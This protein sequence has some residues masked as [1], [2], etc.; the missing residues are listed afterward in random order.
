MDGPR[1]T[2]ELSR[3]AAAVLQER[4]IE[5]ARL[6]AE[7][8]LASVLGLK[9]LDLY[10]QFDR[11]VA[12]PELER[13]RTVIRRRLR[14][15]PV[16]YI[17][18]EAAFRNLVLHVDR[19]VLI[20]RPETEILVGE[21]LKW[22][23][24]H[25]PETALDIG[26]G[27]GAIALS[28][29]RESGLARIVATDASEDALAMAR[30]NAVRLGLADRIEF[31]PG[32]T[33]AAVAPESRFDI[34]ASNPPYVAE[35]DRDTLEPEVREYEPAMALFAGP[36]GLA[37]V[38]AIVSGAADRLTAGGLLALEVGQG[39]AS[40][41]ARRIADTGRFD[42]ARIVDDLAGCARVVLAESQ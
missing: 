3:Q 23:T 41:V 36:D 31:R 28:L 39:Q 10:L 4:G 29:A 2:L 42:D 14:R 24:T 16:Q 38:D 27:S 1:T 6:E 12:E 30:E 13:F 17:V 11:P 34:I 22:A 19:R 9:R 35:A 33:W 25:G 21:V 32:E 37:V 26:T 7:L 15:E 18:G 8:L 40:I 5:N 20:P